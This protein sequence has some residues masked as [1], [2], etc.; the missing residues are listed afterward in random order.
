MTKRDRLPKVE[1]LEGELDDLEK[2]IRR[3]AD[4]VAA[5][6]LAHDAGLDPRGGS[7]GVHVAAGLN[8]YVSD[9]AMDV[10]DEQGKKR[11]R[12][13]IYRAIAEGI[14]NRVEQSREQLGNVVASLGRGML[15]ETFAQPPRRSS[16]AI[17]SQAE[18]EASLEAKRR[19]EGRGDAA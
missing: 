8:D 7:D 4:I 17:L 2:L 14:F 6:K 18:L 19:R 9:A 1:A 3:R 12:A 10:A 5:Y 13:A 15:G 16:D 11:N